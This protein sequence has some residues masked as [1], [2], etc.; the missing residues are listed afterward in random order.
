[1]EI[2]DGRGGLWAGLVIEAGL[3][4]MALV[5]MIL[6]LPVI[7][8][9]LV[10]A[11]LWSGL[12][13]LWLA[14]SVRLRADE[15]GLRGRL[16]FDEV[17]FVWPDVS[18]LRQPQSCASSRRRP[19]AIP[20]RAASRPVWRWKK[21]P[22]SIRIPVS[23]MKTPSRRRAIFTELGSDGTGRRIQSAM[24]ELL[25]ALLLGGTVEGTVFFDGVPPKM[26]ELKRASDPFCARTRYRSEE[27][28]VRGGKLANAVVH[29][30]GA[31]PASPPPTLHVLEQLD[32]R[33]Q[34]HVS[35]IVYGQDLQIVN[36]DPTLHNVHAYVGA[37]SHF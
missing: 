26:E 11:L 13:V 9:A 17:D 2:A 18:E 8:L 1:M 36:R 5:A 32:C 28:L 33:Y 20:S 12:I 35:G 21:V 7:G 19:S 6:G 24:I 14:F 4:G 23:A 30:V 10:T 25:A 34:P 16:G 15:R 27:V 37:R 22:P 3:L 31:P 29:I